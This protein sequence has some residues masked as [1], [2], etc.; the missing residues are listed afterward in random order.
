M[1]TGLFT[2]WL[3]GVIAGNPRYKNSWTR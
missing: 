1:G 2:G 3:R